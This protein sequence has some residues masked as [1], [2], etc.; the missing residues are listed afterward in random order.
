MALIVLAVPLNFLKTYLVDLNFLNGLH[1]FYWSLLYAFHRFAKY[2]K[3]KEYF[4]EAKRAKE[5]G[6]RP[7]TY[8]DLD[9][10]VKGPVT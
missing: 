4:D 7:L 5:G 3:I 9:K 6:A 10:K 8:I 2:I 1:G